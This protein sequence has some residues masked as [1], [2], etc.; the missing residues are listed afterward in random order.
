M[1]VFPCDVLGV[2]S[3]YFS[4]ILKSRRK[5]RKRGRRRRRR[6]KKKKTNNLPLIFFTIGK[7]RI[8]QDFIAKLPKSRSFCKDSSRDRSKMLTPVHP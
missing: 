1:Y 4:R 2:K 7:S 8:R 3:R 6:K 5:R